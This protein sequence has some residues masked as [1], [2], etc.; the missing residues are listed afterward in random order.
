MRVHDHVAPSVLGR[1]HLLDASPNDRAIDLA[2]ALD[3]P[4]ARAEH[5]SAARDCFKWRL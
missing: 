1:H 4:T 5:D 2:H 3:Y